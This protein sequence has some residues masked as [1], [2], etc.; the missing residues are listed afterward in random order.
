MKDN[1][2]IFWLSGM[3]KTGKST[4]ARTVA[5]ELQDSGHLGASFFFSRDVAD[6]RHTGLFVTTVAKQ[7]IVDS[8][9]T[10]QTKISK[11]VST[12]PDIIHKSQCDQWKA[13]VIRPLSQL[14]FHGVIR[15]LV[16]QVYLPRANSRVLVIVV[17]ALDECE[18]DEDIR[19]VLQL[20]ANIGE[21]AGVRLR[22]FVTSR[23]MTPVLLGS[24]AMPVTV[25]RQVALDDLSPDTVNQD[26]RTFLKSRFAEIRIRHGAAVTSWPRVDQLE[27][28]VKRANG[29]FVYAARMCLFLEADERVSKNRLSRV[30]EQ[31][32]EEALSVIDDIYIN[33]LQRSLPHDCDEDV[34][35]KFQQLINDVVKPIVLLLHPLSVDSVA[36]LMQAETGDVLGALR[37]LRSVI[38]CPLDQGSTIRLLHPSFRKFLMSTRRCSDRRFSVDEKEVHHVLF[39]RCFWTISTALKLYMRSEEGT[40]VDSGN[41][42]KHIPAYFQYACRFWVTHLLRSGKIVENEANIVSFF[43]ENF[44]LWLE[45]LAWLGKVHEAVRMMTDLERSVVGNQ[46]LVIV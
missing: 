44:L 40:P 7:L 37:D 35:C 43:K 16:R 20:F 23:P 13:L 28:L 9:H 36:H 14:R 2:C 30:P 10:L 18:N 25:Y 5:R 26:I 31:D 34:R 24:Q 45:T 17:D 11:V 46:M 15:D 41:V 38:Y 21:M 32:S 8:R 39:M 19:N 22:I 42:S 4:I 33:I 27:V 29:L 12:S 6:V 3:A 1:R